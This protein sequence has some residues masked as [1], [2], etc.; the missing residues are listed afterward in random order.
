MKTFKPGFILVF[1]VLVFFFSCRKDDVSTGTGS[2]A[3]TGLNKSLML[4]LVNEQR[5]KG[6]NCGSV[7]YHAT[8]TVVWN[9]QLESAAVAHA[10]DMY[11]NNYFSHTGSDNSTPGDRIRNAGY[12]WTA[13]GENIAKGY[14]T[15]QAV[16]AA[17]IQSEEHCI[18]IMNPAFTEFGAAKAGSYWVQEFG[19]R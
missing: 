7:Y 10:A 4:Q 18:N 11:K 17:W 8:T 19:T 14:T 16:M 12:N 13:Y 3:S 2:T 5:Q 9:N 15:E 1:F 6:C